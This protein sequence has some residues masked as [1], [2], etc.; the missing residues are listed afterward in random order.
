[1]RTLVLASL[2][3]GMVFGALDVA[4]PAFADL[5]GAAESAGIALAGLALG[6][7][8]GGLIY[9][10]RSWPWDLPARYLVLIGALAGMI[11]L[12]ALSGGLPVF[13]LVLA[14]AGLVVAP[15]T[16]I[17]YTL[18]DRVA[19][20]GTATEATT[21]MILG[22]AVGGAIGAAHAGLAVERWGATRGILVASAGALLSEL[23]LLSRLDTIRR[24][25]EGSA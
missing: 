19:P 14:L 1:M 22:Y 8:V 18:L 21:W 24:P 11:A 4:A 20:R 10:S 5:H 2:P 7:M 12:A 3:F 9:G 16:T 23:V 25:Y 15:A 13:V 6:S 17:I